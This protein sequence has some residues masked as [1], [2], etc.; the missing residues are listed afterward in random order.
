[1]HRITSNVKYSVSIKSILNEDDIGMLTSW[2]A[3]GLG[4]ASRISPSH[5]P[6]NYQGIKGAQPGECVPADPIL[7][8]CYPM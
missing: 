2:T 1:M 6:N 7:C 5:L 3:E 8:K 4:T